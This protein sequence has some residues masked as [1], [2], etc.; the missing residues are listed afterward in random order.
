MVLLTPRPENSYFLLLF[1][2]LLAKAPPLS[3]PIQPLHSWTEA[4]NCG[5][6]NYYCQYNYRVTL[7]TNRIASWLLIKFFPEIN[8]LTPWNFIYATFRYMIFCIKMK[9]WKT[10]LYP[11]TNFSFEQISN[12]LPSE[13][14]ACVK[15]KGL[16]ALI[17]FKRKFWFSYN[18][19]QFNR[20]SGR[21]TNISTSISIKV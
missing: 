17:S 15:Y 9:W 12:H 14:F 4:N 7:I 16:Y 2:K 1:L 18:Q 5:Y 20:M 11:E 6:T 8:Y 10:D 21:N 19:W 3:I 13:D